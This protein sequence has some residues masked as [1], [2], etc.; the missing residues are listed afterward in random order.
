MLAC[1]RNLDLRKWEAHQPA[2]YSAETG[3]APPPNAPNAP[4]FPTSGTQWLG[5][6]S[7]MLLQSLSWQQP[8]GMRLREKKH[9]L[10]AWLSGHPV[11]PRVCPGSSQITWGLGFMGLDSKLMA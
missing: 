3:S 8:P 2:D 5:P 4:W 10:P 7:W 1:V 11:C 9:F 6:G